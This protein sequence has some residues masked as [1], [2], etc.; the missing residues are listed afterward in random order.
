[1]DYYERFFPHWYSSSVSMLAGKKHTLLLS[2][3]PGFLEKVTYGNGSPAR[4]FFTLASGP[5]SMA[6]SINIVSI[7]K[8]ATFCVTSDES[9]I[10][11]VP[12]FIGY[13]NKQLKELGLN[14]ESDEEGSD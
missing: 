3:V 2:N 1:M 12:E 14:Y 6:T 9:Q 7:H 13:F 8:R 10:D 5:G 4:R 11:N